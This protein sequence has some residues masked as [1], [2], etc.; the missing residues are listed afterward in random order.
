M[1]T[2]SSELTKNRQGQ[3]LELSRRACFLFACQ[4]TVIF[5][6]LWNSG[7]ATAAELEQAF[8]LVQPCFCHTVSEKPVRPS[9]AIRMGFVHVVTE[10]DVVGREI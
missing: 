5:H 2:H 1:P 8:F 3:A 4:M 9:L 6:C 10:Q 7:N